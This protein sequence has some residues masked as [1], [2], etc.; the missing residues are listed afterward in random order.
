MAAHVSIN[1]WSTA[2][3]VSLRNGQHPWRLPSYSHCKTSR[4]NR[5]ICLHV[6]PRVPIPLSTT[7]G[8]E[9]LCLNRSQPMVISCEEECDVSNRIDT[10]K[11]NARRAMMTAS[12]P[13]MTMKLVDI[14][15]RLGLGYNFEEEIKTLL[16]HHVDGQPDDD[17]YVTALRFRILR[18]NNLH[19]NPDIFQPFIDANGKFGESLVGD[20]EGLLSLYEASYL[21]ANGEDVLSNA[22]EFAST[23]LRKSVYGLTQTLRE[24]ILQSFELPR[25]MRMAR[26][27]ARRYIEEYG[28]DSDHNPVILELAKLEY[29]Q[30]QSLHQ[31]ELAEIR[32][33]WRHMDLASKL[34]F[35]RDRPIE[36]FLWTVGLLPEPK[37]STIRIELA[38]TISILL[39]ID[40]I[41]DTYG[42]Y[43]DLIQFTKAIQRWDLEAMEQLPEYMKICYMALYNTTNEI[44][45]VIQKNHGLSVLPYLRKTW[46]DTIQAMMVEAEW[47][48]RGHTPNLKD[49][50]ENGITTAG[51]YMAL[52][53][54]FFLIGEGVT[55]ENTRYLIH[56]YPRFFSD[57]GKILR[58]WDDLGTSKEEQERGDI[59]SSIQLLMREN[60]ITNEKDGRKQIMQLIQTSWKQLNEALVEPNMFPL[61]IIKV[62][63]NMS[64]ASQVVY[65]HDDDD[66]DTYFSSVDDHAT[67][68]FFTPIDLLS[69]TLE[70]IV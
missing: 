40:D 7:Q 13:M 16:E 8:N 31:M 35:A 28:N 46:I 22:K 34:T 11:E 43:D 50:I 10:L 38:K 4:M 17:L 69:C 24:K 2:N 5:H 54:L 67:S 51:T 18:H 14:I 37:Y 60:N 27:E 70:L 55:E 36:C 20:T 66:E 49:Y 9:F 56:S 29:N 63:L 1:L 58:L 44:C 32:T 23:H 12:N 61:S 19:P 48:R 6:L 15:Q 47:V 59:S 21:G 53:H 45:F 25:H 26:L 65:Q 30:V 57:A 64:R 33:W 3:V 42:S 62:A 52:V 41:F 39:V 68:L